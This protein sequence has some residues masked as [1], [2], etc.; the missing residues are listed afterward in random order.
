MWHSLS[1]A[2]PPVR[3]MEN[4]VVKEHCRLE[5]RPAGGEVTVWNDPAHRRPR[6]GGGGQRLWRHGRL[7]ALPASRGGEGRHAAHRADP[8]R[9]GEPRLPSAKW[10]L[11]ALAV[12]L[13][14][15]AL[16][17]GAGLA[18]SSVKAPLAVRSLLV[19]GARAD[20][21]LVVVGERGHILVSTDDGSSW[22]QANVPTRS[23][24][25]A[26]HMH[27][28]HRGWAVGH[29]A[30]ILRTDDGG[31][32]WQ[33]V[34]HAPKE[35]R[36]L[37]DVW[38]ADRH[39]GIAVGA[40]G[41]F[42]VTRDGGRSWRSRIIDEDDYHLNKI[43]PTGTRRLYI[44]AEAGAAYRSDDGGD[45]WRRL[46]PPYTG[47]WFAGLAVG[48]D[49]LLLLGL[50]GRMV[51]SVDGGKTWT[52]VDSGTLATLTGA[53]RAASGEILVTGLA[54]TVLTS[55][56][57]GLSFLPRSLALR[58]GIAA[59]VPLAGDAWLLVGEFGVRRLAAAR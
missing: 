4:T 14:L 53:V 31:E 12:P 8:G 3:S 2:P 26:V 34:H 44:A 52:R 20:S 50:R 51:R 21:R 40:Y 11:R 9:A 16:S 33:L 29:D 23:L 13:I 56:D 54:G 25:A 38:F 49:D 5:A 45:T 24:L 59:A 17:P 35:D 18:E 1:H 30:V 41:Y 10:R 6:L 43:V 48:G 39:N 36:P 37:L 55:R 22:K 15:A 57:D 42:L 46:A 58:R 32:N 27:D 7:L 19:D 28:Q 47:S